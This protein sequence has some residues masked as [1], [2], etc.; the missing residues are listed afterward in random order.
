MGIKYTGNETIEE[1]AVHTESKPMIKDNEFYNPP[2]PTNPTMYTKA[3]VKE[4]IK[5]NLRKTFGEGIGE[6]RV[7]NDFI[8]EMG[9]KEEYPLY[10]VLD[11]LGL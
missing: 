6:K 10:L 11:W 5:K 9:D 8:Q 2:E 3:Q 4:V 7:W 1:H